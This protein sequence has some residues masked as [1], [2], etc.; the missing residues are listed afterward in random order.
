VLGSRKDS[1][2]RLRLI[3][4]CDGLGALMNPE[5]KY[6]YFWA[7]TPVAVTVLVL[8]LARFL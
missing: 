5:I 6:V 1:K 4:A 3:N 8:T 7:I 2:G